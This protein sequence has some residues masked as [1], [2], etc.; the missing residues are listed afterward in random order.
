MEGVRVQLERKYL[1][2]ARYGYI[3]SVT[4]NKLWP[5]MCKHI[6]R[7]PD[8]ISIQ[9]FSGPLGKVSM[10]GSNVAKELRSLMYENEWPLLVGNPPAS[11][12]G[13]PIV[14]KTKISVAAVSDDVLMDQQAA[15]I[16]PSWVPQTIL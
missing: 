10:S 14:T 7:P 4:W 9:V 3:Q 6:C 2:P 8:R 15:F 11:V 13:H 1:D 5:V 16:L 12:G